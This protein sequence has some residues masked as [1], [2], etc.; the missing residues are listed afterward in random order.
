[1][2]TCHRGCGVRRD[3]NAHAQLA[4]VM[5]VRSVCV[6]VLFA[7]VCVYVLVCAC[8]FVCVRLSCM[9][10]CGFCSAFECAPAFLQS[11]MIP[12]ALVILV[13]VQPCLY[14]SAREQVCAHV[15]A[16]VGRW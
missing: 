8:V 11:C 7:C 2:P 10:V 4:Y 12:F 16:S 13:W 5:R 9:S 15:F 6:R 1:M 14:V 3:V